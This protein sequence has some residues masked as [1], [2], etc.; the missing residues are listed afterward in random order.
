MKK[1]FIVTAILL[2]G[3]A[4]A[5][6][7]NILTAD[8]VMAKV[9]KGKLYTLVFLKPGKSIPKKGQP[10]Q[11]MQ[12][13]H[14]IHLFTMEKEGKISIFGPVMRNEDLTGI[15]VFNSTDKEFIKNELKNDPYIKGGYLKYELLD[16]FSIPGQKIRE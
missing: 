15:I 9:A 3:I 5:Y 7:Q 13:D 12:L 16:W 2:C 4:S 6:S 10:A 8:S 1:K 14:L 11:Q